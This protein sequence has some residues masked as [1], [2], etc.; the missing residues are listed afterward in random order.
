M[1]VPMGLLDGPPGISM[2]LGSQAGLEAPASPSGQVSH[3]W[4][5]RRG[6]R[7]PASVPSSH[8][9]TSRTKPVPSWALPSVRGTAEHTLTWA[10]SLESPRLHFA[11]VTYVQFDK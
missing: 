9:N 4:R 1:V 6:R 5:R 10:E 7:G 3:P 8:V 2:A 11:R